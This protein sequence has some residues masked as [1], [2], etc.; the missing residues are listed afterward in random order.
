MKVPERPV[1]FSKFTTAI[2]GP[3]APVVLPP[4]TQQV[5]YEAEFVVVIGKL[6]KNVPE[7]RALEYVAGYT[8]MND[9]SARDLQI[10]LGG[11]Q[12]VWGRAPS[13]RSRRSVPPW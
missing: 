7:A 6:A 4:V 12:W 13:T 5:N 8:I 11:G 1:V 9:V 3:G 10:K 2:A